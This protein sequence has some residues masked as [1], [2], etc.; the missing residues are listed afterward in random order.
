MPIAVL[1]SNDSVLSMALEAAWMAELPEPRQA[2]IARWP[3]VRARHRSLIASR[4]LCEG[5]RQFGHHGT[6]LA[7]LRYTARGRPSLDLPVDFSISHCD[8]RI[9]CAVST[10][11]PVGI[12]VERVGALT[13]GDL[14]RYLN[15]SERS[16]VGR[17]PRRFYTVWTRKEAVAKAAGTDSLADL[18]DI[19]TRPAGEGAVFAGRLWQ[20]WALEMGCT[21][22]AHLAFRD[23]RTH[24]RATQVSRAWLEHDLCVDRP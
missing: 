13:A 1:I 4:L 8:G 9:A 16:W 3:S 7:S 15:D 5:L 10:D 24:W 18:R 17:D 11:G 2:Q 21:H 22:I 20:T 23:R 14:P 12:D 6:V 19:D